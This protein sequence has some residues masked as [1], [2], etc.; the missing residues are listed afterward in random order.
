MRWNRAAYVV[1]IDIPSVAPLDGFAWLGSVL[2]L[3]D[4]VLTDSLLNLNLHDAFLDLHDSVLNSVLVLNLVLRR[5]NGHIIGRFVIDAT[6]LAAFF[7]IRFAVPVG[8]HAVVPHAGKSFRQNVQRPPP[9]KLN[10]R[11]RDR[12]FFFGLT[13]QRVFFTA[14]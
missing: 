10:L 11:N 5:V 1:G 13:R 4:F 7:Q 3:N 8:T 2:R 6:Q 14:P 9:H 12:N